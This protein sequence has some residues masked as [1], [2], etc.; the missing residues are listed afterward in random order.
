MTAKSYTRTEL[1]LAALTVLLS[2]AAVAASQFCGTR[3]A[4]GFDQPPNQ[5]RREHYL[6]PVYGYAVDIPAALSGFA[7]LPGPERGFGILLSQAPRAF[8]RVDASYDALFDLTAQGVHR[9]DLGRMRQH[10]TVVDDQAS[11]SALA[12]QPGM[13]FLTRVRCEGNA[14]LF[15]HEAVIVVLNRE[16]YRLDLQTVPERYAAD[17]KILNAMLRSW[18]WEKIR[19]AQPTAP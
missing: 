16:I 12:N 14:P 7:Q 4:P 1:L 17:V 11:P 18:R 8:L 5:L 6:N 13:R 9:S 10:D 3:P 2:N 15:I 19:P